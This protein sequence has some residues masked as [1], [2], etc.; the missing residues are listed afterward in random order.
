MPTAHSN[1]QIKLLFIQKNLM[2]K[3][4]RKFLNEILASNRLEYIGECV[5][6]LKSGRT[7]RISRTD[8]DGILEIVAPMDN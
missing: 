4:F 6:A 2:I 8:I 5:H 1:S 3:L 7:D